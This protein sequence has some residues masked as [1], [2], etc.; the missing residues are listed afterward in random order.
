MAVNKIYI[1][2]NG[3]E[4][5]INEPLKVEPKIANIEHDSNATSH[6]EPK[7][8][9]TETQTRAKSEEPTGQ[10]KQVEEATKAKEQANVVSE[11]IKEDKLQEYTAQADNSEQYSTFNF[12]VTELSCL[13]TVLLEN[14]K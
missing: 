10:P 13:M 6:I 5:G 8:E 11:S 14:L 1:A 9:K 3:S 4:A 12:Q 2:D 7:G